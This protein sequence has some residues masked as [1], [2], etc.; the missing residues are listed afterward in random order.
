VLNS[1]PPCNLAK[2]AVLSRT[3]FYADKGNTTDEY[4]QD[5]QKDSAF[6]DVTSVICRVR[7]L[8]MLHTE[9]DR[10]V[11]SQVMKGTG[12]LRRSVTSW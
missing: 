6:S 8:A 3:T 2:C 9:T 1:T 11:T 5:E 12:L 4:G 10:M 7:R